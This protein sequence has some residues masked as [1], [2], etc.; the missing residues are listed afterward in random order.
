VTP[1]LVETIGPYHR[2]TLTVQKQPGTIQEVVSIQVTLPAGARLVHST[3]Q[4]A[5]SYALEQPILEYR[6]DLTTDQRIE[7]LYER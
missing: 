3:P 2:Y 7:I 4:P 5:T 1:A 6:L